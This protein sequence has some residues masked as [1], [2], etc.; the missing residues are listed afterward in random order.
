MSVWLTVISILV[1]SVLT[2]ADDLCTSRAALVKIDEFYIKQPYSAEIELD[3]KNYIE[4]FHSIADDAE[5]FT[6][7]A[8]KYDTEKELDDL[9]PS[10]LIP[11][12][13]NFNLIQINTTQGSYLTD[14]DQKGASVLDFDP[15][16]IGKIK[17]ILTDLEI[18]NTPMKTYVDKQQITNSKGIIFKQNAK[19]TTDEARKIFEYFVKFN[20]DGTFSYPSSTTTL[21]DTL[22]AFCLKPNN[23]WD[24]KGPNRQ[25]W[26]TIINKILPTISKAKQWY[27][28]FNNFIQILPNQESIYKKMK[29]KLLLNTPV[30]LTRITRFLKQFNSE[31]KWESSLPSDFNAFQQYFQDFRSISKLFKQ[32]S[33]P[34]TSTTTTSPVPVLT[35]PKPLM[36]LAALDKDRLQRFINIE[37]TKVNITGEIET[38]PLFKHEDDGKITARASF[39]QYGESDL[40][41]IYNVKPLVFNNRITTVTHVVATYKNYLATMS[42]PSPFACEKEENDSSIKVCKGYS[43]PGIAI[44]SP[45][46]SIDCGNS[47]ATDEAITD[48]TKCPSMPAPSFPMAHR[49]NCLNSSAIISSNKQLLVRVYCDN[50]SKRP[51]KLTTFPSLLNTD[52]E[53]RSVESRVES[54]LLPQLVTKFSQERSLDLEIVTLPTLL[55]TS[56]SPSREIATTISTPIETT[57]QI[58]QISRWTDLPTWVIPTTATTFIALFFTISIIVYCQCCKNSKCAS[59]SKMS[60][61]SCCSQKSV[62]RPSRN[63]CCWC[64]SSDDPATSVDVLELAEKVVLKYPNFSE[65]DK[66]DL[67]QILTGLK[68]PAYGSPTPVQI[69]NAPLEEEFN[70]PEQI[71][72]QKELSKSFSTIPGSR[73]LANNQIAASAVPLLSQ[74]QN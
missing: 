9:E 7:I 4:E 16:D 43:T 21:A 28:I 41:K 37:N 34:S 10:A 32:Q 6:S 13:E 50:M 68:T 61:D 12:S 33:V 39:Q 1:G 57:T 19:L 24:L 5:K 53:I 73:N 72:I 56:I 3:L 17:Q 42:T 2:N 23:Q 54:I 25:K 49:V 69:A 26:L 15:S 65:K 29:D 31:L 30:P 55:S 14:C 20:K 46:D 40:I 64:K 18:E 11:F 71:L 52:C 70:E 44:L 38:T 74:K 27:T 8:S 62:G 67:K 59:V 58:N 63:C 51:F 36:A 48:F 47:L 22:Q 35:F 45:E 60:T 66:Q